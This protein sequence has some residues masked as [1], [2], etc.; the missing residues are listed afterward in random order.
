MTE[1]E[2]VGWHHEYNGYE[3]EQT[4]GDSEGQGN[5]ACCSPWGHKELVTAEQGKKHNDKRVNIP[6]KQ[7][8]PKCICTK[9]ISG[10]DSIG[11]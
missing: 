1:D 7:N 2:I 6:C 11:Y 3:F 5:P 9:E 10:L 4:P 8:N